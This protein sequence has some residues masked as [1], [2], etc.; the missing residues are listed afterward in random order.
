M[1]VSLPKPFAAL[2]GAERQKFAHAEN[3]TA[4]EIQPLRHVANARQNRTNIARA[5][6]F[7]FTGIDFLQ[8]E[9]RA[10]ESGFSGPVRANQRHQLA[11]RHGESDSP[12]YGMA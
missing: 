9:K 6:K 5:K 10:Q 1:G 2:A 8:S 11:F 7:H 4:F 3:K 12:Q